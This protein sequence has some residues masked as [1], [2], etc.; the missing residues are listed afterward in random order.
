MEYFVYEIIRIR[1][2]SYCIRYPLYLK[3]S[4]DI[5]YHLII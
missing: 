3:M 2:L 1:I 4:A 5:M